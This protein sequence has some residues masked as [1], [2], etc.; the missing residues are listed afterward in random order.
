MHV[1]KQIMTWGEVDFLKGRPEPGASEFVTVPHKW[2]AEHFDQDDAK[3]LAKELNDRFG[4]RT[5]GFG[6]EEA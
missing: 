2:A 3:E 1:V 4:D 6:V 5:R